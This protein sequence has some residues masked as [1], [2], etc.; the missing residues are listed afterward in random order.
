MVCMGNICRSPMAQTVAVHLSKQLDTGVAVQVDSAGTHAGQGGAPIDPRARTVLTQRGYPPLA[1]CRARQIADRDF[2][3]FDMILAMDQANMTELRQL[4]PVEHN[5]KLRL[6]MEFAPGSH[7][8][9]IP[10][11]YYGP[12]KGFE[13]VLDM[14]EAGVR[15]LFD[16]VRTIPR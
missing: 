5:H 4:C 13:L 10:D 6:L 3:K 11:P 16:Y 15:G 14:C 9:E 1:S 12:P 2:D 7:G 8:L